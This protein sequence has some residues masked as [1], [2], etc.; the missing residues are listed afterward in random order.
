MHEDIPTL[1]SM[2]TEVLANTQSGAVSQGATDSHGTRNDLWS[3][4]GLKKLRRL[5]EAYHFEYSPRSNRK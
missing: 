4:L 1:E 3:A 2:T 5:Q